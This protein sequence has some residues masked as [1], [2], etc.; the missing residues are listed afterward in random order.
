[1]SK[2]FLLSPAYLYM[3]VRSGISIKELLEDH[4]TVLRTTMVERLNSAPS[5][6]FGVFLAFDSVYKE[7][8]E[9]D[10]E[11]SNM[12]TQNDYVVDIA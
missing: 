4:D 10:E 5:I 11:K 8:G 3:V 7:N 6:D 12:V 1:M 2:K 9:I